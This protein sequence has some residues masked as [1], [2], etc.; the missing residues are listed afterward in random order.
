MNTALL[1]LGWFLLGALGAL[2]WWMVS[3]PLLR[4]EGHQL[5]GWAR[6]A[7]WCVFWVNILLLVLLGP[8]GAFSLGPVSLGVWWATSSTRDRGCSRS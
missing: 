5:P 6:R 7:T 2:A 1:V 8:L 3:K 4:E